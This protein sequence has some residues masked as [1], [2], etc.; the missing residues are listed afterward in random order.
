MSNTTRVV[1]PRQGA[2]LPRVKVD[3]ATRAKLVEIGTTIREARMRA[4]ISQATLAER[5]GMHR[6]NYL[7]IEKGR[8]NVTIETLMR[9]AIGLGVNLTVGYSAGARTK[10]PRRPRST[11]STIAR[12]GAGAA[13]TTAKMTTGARKRV[14]RTGG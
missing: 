2:T 6:E 9:I 12:P 5:I 1:E 8:L 4:G 10:P 7:R 11:T 13:R 14:R 3:P